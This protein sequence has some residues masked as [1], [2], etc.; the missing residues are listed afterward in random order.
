MSTFQ[1]NGL[2]DQAFAALF[3]LDDTGL[4]A[5][6]MQRLRA[7]A[8]PGYPCRVSLEDA[9]L[10]EELLL[11]PYE[12]LAAASPYRASGPIFVRRNARRAVFPAGE[13]PASLQRRLISLRAYDETHRMRHAEVCEG[14]ALGA[15]IEYALAD[16][17]IAYLHLHNAKPGCFACRVDRVA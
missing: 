10:G 7:D 9:E 12:H 16:A 2:A 3:D 5:R 8:F 17:A 11:L 1:I 14:A 13:I 6:H 15:R 4:A